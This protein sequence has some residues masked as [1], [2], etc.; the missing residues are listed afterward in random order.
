[1]LEAKLMDSQLFREFE[2]IPKR[3]ENAKFDFALIDV[4]KSLCA[5]PHF[6]PYDDNR[7]RICPTKN[8]RLGFVNASTIS[9]SRE[10][11]CL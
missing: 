9:V 10:V 7:V 4:N 6:L 8:N 5:D 3:K 1:M 11:I 2:A